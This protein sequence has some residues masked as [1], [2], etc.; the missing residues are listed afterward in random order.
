MS[1]ATE[2]HR[3]YHGLSVSLECYVCHR[4]YNNRIS[5]AAHLRKAHKLTQKMLNQSS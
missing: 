5:W 2:H 1:N 3:R 4:K